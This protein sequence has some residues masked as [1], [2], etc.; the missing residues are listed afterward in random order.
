VS[1]PEA[2]LAAGLA[3]EGLAAGDLLAFNGALLAAMAAPGPALLMAIRASLT[4]GRAAGIATGLGLGLVAAGWTLA[5]FL[6][7]EALFALFPWAYAAVRIAGAAYLLWVAWGMW[8]EARAP[9]GGAPPRPGHR[10]VVDGMLV[11]LANPK[12]VLFAAAVIVVIFPPDLS[13]GARL[14][15]AANHLVLEVAVYAALATL[16]ATPAARAGYLRLKPVFDRV[17]GLV[18]GALGLRLLIGRP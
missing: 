6:G 16:L 1:A 3:A 10:Y 11:N 4:G 2:G 15:I 18:L 13:L 14:L 9:V 7:L 5:A 8:R 17:A 12:S